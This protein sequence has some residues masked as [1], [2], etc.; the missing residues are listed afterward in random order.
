M[1]NADEY[2]SRLNSVVNRTDYLYEK[3][4]K[5]QGVNSYESKILYMLRFTEMDSQKSMAENYGMP[6][7]TINTVVA[8]LSMYGY[9]TLETDERD[10]RSKRITLTQKGKEYADFV[11]L[12]LVGCEKRALEKMG[13]KRI[14]IMIDTMKE[15]AD[16]L[17]DEL[18]N[19]CFD[20]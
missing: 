4:T 7:Q 3:W 12:P 9:V 8:K 16:L 10:K 15:Y 18:N 11:L 14:G 17:E 19:C 5:L 2:I 6:K 20:K 13:E 1:K